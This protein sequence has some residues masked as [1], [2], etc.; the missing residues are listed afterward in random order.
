MEMRTLFFQDILPLI[1]GAAKQI[2]I[3]STLK[4]TP[5]LPTK[6]CQDSVQKDD[7]LHPTE[8]A[9]ALIKICSQISKHRTAH[10]SVRTGKPRIVTYPY[11]HIFSSH[12]LYSVYTVCTSY[13]ELGP[14]FMSETLHVRRYL[15]RQVP[16]LLR[17]AA[18][19][20]AAV[21]FAPLS[22]CSD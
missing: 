2:R 4:Q 9:S 19:D 1:S 14:S 13:L 21:R 18:H 5:T 3:A 10:S 16:S 6:Y 7:I 22:G 12:M 17:R 8:R 15:R 11:I 20:D